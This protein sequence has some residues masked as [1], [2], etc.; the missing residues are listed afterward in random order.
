MGLGLGKSKKVAIK[1]TPKEV[2][3][4]KEI[5]KTS[6]KG[7]IAKTPDVAKTPKSSVKATPHSSLKKTGK[8]EK[9]VPDKVVVEEIPSS[10]RQ[11]DEPLAA[12]FS[13]SEI[14]VL[15][16]RVILNSQSKGY[17]DE[18]EI[19]IGFV[20]V[21]ASASDINLVKEHLTK[22]GLI[23]KQSEGEKKEVDIDK[24]L[25]AASVDDSV[26][27]YLRE[28]GRYPLLSSEEEL[29]IAKRMSEG[30]ETAKMK[31]NQS[32]LRLV[33]HIAKRYTGRT[34]LMF[35][36][37]IQEGNMGLM[38]AV[39][40]FDYRKGFRFSTYATWWIRQSITRAIA[41]QGRTI[42]IPAHMVEKINKLL[43][44]SRLL[45]Q[46]L[47]REPTVTEI[48]L[49]M[50]MTPEKVEEIRA[51][52]QDTTSLDSPLGEDG[53][54]KLEDTIAD[55]TIEDPAAH[56]ARIMLK[57]Q[58]LAVVNSLTPREQ[59]VVRLRYGI[60]DGKMRTLEEVGKLFSVTRERIRQI[61]AKALRKL[62]N[63]M[64]TRKLKDFVEE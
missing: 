60:D 35:Q 25:A 31:L 33:V 3:S 20:E 30:C 5:V 11:I 8:I 61:E 34:S 53:D 15:L 64:R 63:P 58:L 21:G 23:I 40:K 9:D 14:E 50:G 54:G 56:A 24:V 37:L 39:T 47:G 32:N 45:Q 27:S 36:D 46:E 42:R 38:R 10:G 6:V 26:K 62:R 59:K 4:K 41:D 1:T 2:A 55:R 48:G 12:G 16:R 57:E 22:S 13:K 44:T 52:S 29:E 51:T 18:D 7:I 17:V 19:S 49:A 28:I 43:K